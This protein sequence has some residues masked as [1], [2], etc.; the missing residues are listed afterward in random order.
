[1]SRWVIT[2]LFLVGSAI[3]TSWIPFSSFFR[4][5]DTMV[6][7]LGH[8]VATLVLSGQVLYIELYA[9][10]SGVTYSYIERGWKMIPL[11]LSGYMSASLF[12]VLLFHFYGQGKLKAGLIAMS[13]LAAV[14][15]G[16]FVN[17]AYGVIWLIGF[18]IVNGIAM[19]FPYDG[20]RKF[21]YLLVSFICLEQSVMGPIYLLVLSVTS[22]GQAGDA[23]NL[24][25]ATDVPAI[26]WSSLF[27]LFALLCARKA[28]ASFVGRGRS[29]A[30]ASRWEGQA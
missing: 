6:H 23:A 1:M 5:V 28:I 8:A 22:P 13:L 3:L 7:E 17:N 24:S 30:R 14:S 2:I 21:Y 25:R 15:L 11:G 26:V 20:V 12:A 10:H 27:L 4:N 19:F 29:R 9:D 16:F 18:M